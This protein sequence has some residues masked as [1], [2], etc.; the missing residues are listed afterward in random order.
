MY[1]LDALRV[2][3]VDMA[4]REPIDRAF[5]ALGPYLDRLEQLVG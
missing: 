3:G 4:T 2:A 1:P 5:G